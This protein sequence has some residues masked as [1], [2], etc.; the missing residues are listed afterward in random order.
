MRIALGQI[1]PIIGNLDHNC[2]K[3]LEMINQAKAQKIELILFPEMCITGYP[4]EDFLLLPDFIQAAQ[5]KLEELI[6]HTKGITAIIGLPRQNPD[7]GKPLYN[8]AAIIH[9]GRLLG[10]QDKSLLP[11]YDVFD[12]QRYFEPCRMTKIWEI[13]NKRIAVTICEDIWQHSSLVKETRYHHDPIADLKEEKPD[14]LLNLSAS[15]FALG[16]MARRMRA[17]SEAAKTLQCP[18]YHCNLVGG[19]DSLIFDGRS[20][21]CDAQGKFTG[22][23]QAFA[24]ELFIA[25]GQ[26][27]EKQDEMQ[28]L[29]EALCLGIRDYFQKQG[30]TKACLGLSGGIDSAVVACLAVK[31]L[32]ATNVLG[33]SMPSRYTSDSSRKDAQGLAKNLAIEFKEIPI[34]APFQSFLD[35]FEPEFKGLKP[36]A[37]EENMQS[38]IRGMILMALSNKKGYII[39]STGNKS[40]MAMGYTTLYGDLCGGLAVLSD[41][42]K[43]NVYALAQWINRKQEIIPQSTITKAPSAELRPNQ[44]DSDSL[45]EYDIIDQVVQL[46]VEEHL[47][48]QEIIKRTGFQSSLVENL[49]QRIHRNEYKRRQS[50]PGLRVSEK[51]FTVGRKFPIVQGWVE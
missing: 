19:N 29:E 28:L 48:I 9:D 7:K 22:I 16:K 1:N 38:R 41:V 42:T 20:Y 44:K 47:P 49:I 37:T 24:E 36:D 33:V 18:V 27:L 25:H 13:A 46:Y 11:T 21:V 12:E 43:H 51:A 10:F 26:N 35:L 5:A 2:A 32:G 39:L 34:E 14:I 40:E 45:P 50:P 6:P 4:P 30:F 8:S 17:G 3:I 23:A 31:A 15:P